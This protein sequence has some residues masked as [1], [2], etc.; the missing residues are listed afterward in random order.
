MKKP[1]MYTRAPG[2]NQPCRLS[3][4]I[5]M[6]LFAAGQLHAQTTPT[7]NDQTTPST[8]QAT[9]KD[10]KA[11]DKKTSKS[12]DGKD[13]TQLNSMTVSGYASSLNRAQQIKR[14]SDTVVDAISAQDA[15]SLP[16]LSV[17]E[18]LQRVPGVA[19]SAFGV[20]ADPDHF[21]IQGSDISLQGLPYTSTLFNGRE[22]FSAGGGQGLNFST[23]S[24]EL[25]GSVVVSKNQTADMIE[26][27]IAGSIDLRTRKPFDSDKDTQAA[28]TVGDYWG[29]L[30]KRGT[31]QIAGLFSHNWNTGIGRFGILANL[32]YDRIDQ[33][34]NAISLVDFQRRCNGCTLPGNR[35]DHYPGLP[36]GTDGPYAYLPI[37]GDLRTQHETSTRF[38]HVLAAQ[39]ESPDKAW[40]ATLEWDR[41]S[42]TETTY[43]HTLQASTDGCAWSDA[44]QCDIPLAGT[45]PV[46]DS[47]GVFQSGIVTAQPSQYT[48][49]NVYTDSKGNQ[50]PMGGLPTQINST[51][52][53]NRYV[54]NDYSFNLKWN[55]NDRLHLNLDAQDTH[56]QYKY[57]YYYIRQLTNAN[58]YIA[59]HGD[60]VPTVKLLSPDPA[61]TTAQYFANPANTYWAAAQDSQRYSWGNQRAFRLDGDF[62]AD[63]GPLSDIQFGFRHTDQSET[64]Q[65]SAF[66][67]VPI[68][69]PSPGI[70]PITAADTPNYVSPYHVNLP[71]FGGGDFG[72]VAPYFNLNPLTQFWQSAAAIKQINQ[73]WLANTPNA[74]GPYYT[75]YDREQYVAGDVFVPGTYYLP[76]EV[77]SNREKT[78]ATYVRL[79]F[80][81]SNLD[82]LSGL[83]I[84]GN[85]GLRYIHTQDDASGYLILPNML[86]TLNGHTI[87]QYCNSGA[88]G[89]APQPGTF[90]ALTPAQQQ[91]YMNFANGAFTPITA[92]SSY[93]N[94]LPSFNL[95]VGW[96]DDLITRFA[97]SESIYRP[98]LVQLQA[99]QSVGGLL[100]Y[101]TNGS[102]EPTVGNGYNG[103]NPYLKP[104]TA[105][106]FD[107]SQEWYF[108]NAGSLTG[109]LFYKQLNHTIQYITSVVDTTVT[110]NGVTYP[111]QYTAGLANLDQKGSV[112]GAELAYQQKY[113]FLPGWL[114]GFGTQMNYTYI[115]P[116]GLGF[117][118]IN[119]C[120]SGYVAPTQCINQLKLPPSELSRD[121]FNFTA[122]YEKGPLSARLAWNWRSQFL[123]SGQEADYPFLPVMAESQGKLD[124]SLIYT[125]NPHVKVALQVSNLLN[126][127]FK[128]REIVN[129][130][131]LSVPKGFFRD[132]TRYN[133]SLRANF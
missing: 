25:I 3:L 8:T 81:N 68:S 22:V 75:N 45:T 28:F 107:L 105:H 46:F 5:A 23:V 33:A 89:P 56:S 85:I 15:G 100:P 115:K 40:S 117:G 77:A 29:S 83:Q 7:T 71:A 34:D 78:N 50:I 11:A 51:G 73:Q 44:D 14:Y 74:V 39:W 111:E 17:T 94:W 1:S 66:N 86:Q 106:N 101:G 95:A 67:Y 131:G 6:T 35:P 61:E 119:Y 55:V 93:G 63:K 88:S 57:A 96:T 124:G 19:V 64:V 72:I 13:V 91:Q 97:F 127:T 38:G 62:D 12:V 4:A 21:S 129:T 125:I 114:S 59:T 27:G 123:I 30:D 120:P 20:A 65:S 53:R 108:A 52:Y 24:P 98:S 9:S 26:G 10:I 116:H 76:Q 99:G 102:T 90:C 122:Y 60:S 80:G 82:F 31:P 112:R 49:P 92:H 47:N 121:T 43:E 79:N 109:M 48:Y 113:D 16:D 130:D 54:T 104:I 37:G 36:E 118:S 58:W 133:L 132:D 18:A 103:S 110:N 84:S 126:S 87:A 128:T 69:T 70:A 2:A 32:A 42:D 41:A